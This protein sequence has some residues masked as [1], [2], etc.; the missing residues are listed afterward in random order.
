MITLM[1]LGS[2]LKMLCQLTEKFTS[3]H[4][5]RSV[6][7]CYYPHEIELRWKTAIL[8]LLDRASLWWLKNKNQLDATYYFI[9]LLIGSTCFGHYYAHH[10]ELATIMLITTLVVSFLV[11]CRLE[12]VSELQPGHYSSLNAPNLQPTANQE[13]NDQCGN[14]QHS[15][16]L[17]MM[18]IVVPETCWAYKKYN[19][20]I[21][22]IQLVFILQKDS[23]FA[24]QLKRL[25]T[26]S[27]ST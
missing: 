24:H 1:F 16:E 13:R 21:S 18:G 5:F 2:Q 19:E 7:L 11:C 22:G 23:K 20:I 25:W 3:S 14:Q 15:R 4:M 17:L 8:C 27:D 9:V 12:V 6:V 10:Q 26:T